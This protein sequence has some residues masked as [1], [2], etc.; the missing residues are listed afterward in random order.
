MESFRKDGCLSDEG[1]HALIAGQ[2]DELG[3][4]EAAQKSIATNNSKVTALEQSTA[5][6]PLRSMVGTRL[7]RMPRYSSRCSMSY[8]FPLT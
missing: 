2:L 6:R 5:A 3:R 7:S 1:L 4:L 8:S